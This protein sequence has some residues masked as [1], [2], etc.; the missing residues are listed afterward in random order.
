MSDIYV[1]SAAELKIESRKKIEQ[2]FIKKHTDAVNFVYA[3][4]KSLIG[5]VLIK[6]GERFYDAT[7][8]GRLAIVK[9][10]LR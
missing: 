4:D 5:G 7:I 2:F 1:T 8:R 3:V 10:N 9:R 6:D